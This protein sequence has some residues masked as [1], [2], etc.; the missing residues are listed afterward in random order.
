[1]NPPTKA[2]ACGPKPT[3]PLLPVDVVDEHDH[4]SARAEPGE[5]RHA[6]V[7]LDD[8]APPTQLAKDHQGGGPEVHG[9]VAPAAHVADAVL[10][11]V[12]R[13]A[14]VVRAEERDPV[15]SRDQP[16]CQALDVELGAT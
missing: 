16:R 13:R 14:L 3:P 11:L 15:T 12:T 6:V 1:M 8:G 9:G 7:D 2:G 5:E 4:A 10:H